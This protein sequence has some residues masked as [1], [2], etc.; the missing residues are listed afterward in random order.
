MEEFID[1]PSTYINWFSLIYI[2]IYYVESSTVT[3]VA[4]LRQTP[5]GSGP[6]PPLRRSPR[7]CQTAHHTQNSYNKYLILHSIVG[8]NI[9]LPVFTVALTALILFVLITEFRHLLL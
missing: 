8:E 1:T 4:Y 5:R 9:V 3:P 2:Y 6:L 7:H